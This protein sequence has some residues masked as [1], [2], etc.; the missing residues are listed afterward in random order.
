MLQLARLTNVYLES[1]PIGLMVV[2]RTIVNILDQSVRGNS[3]PHVQ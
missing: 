1:S 3:E 2:G